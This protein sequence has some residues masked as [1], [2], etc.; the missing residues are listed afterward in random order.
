MV[1]FWN[2]SSNSRSIETI[3]WHFILE[4]AEFWTHFFWG[5]VDRCDR[6]RQWRWYITL[7]MFSFFKGEP[8][9]RHNEKKAFLWFDPRESKRWGNPDY[10]LTLIILGFD[11][12]LWTWLLASSSITWSHRIPQLGF[13]YISFSL[14]NIVEDPSLL[15]QRR[16]F[17]FFCYYSI[18]CTRI[19]PI[20]PTC[21]SSWPRKEDSIFS[22]SSSPGVRTLDP[23]K[24]GNKRCWVPLKSIKFSSFLTQWAFRN[25]SFLALQSLLSLFM[26]FVTAQKDLAFHAEMWQEF[27]SQVCF[28]GF[29]YKYDWSRIS[30]VREGNSMAE[31]RSWT[32]RFTRSSNNQLSMTW[33]ICRKDRFLLSHT[34]ISLG[35]RVCYIR[36]IY[37]TRSREIMSFLLLYQSYYKPN[38][39]RREMNE[40]MARENVHEHF[41]H[42][43]SPSVLQKFVHDDNVHRQKLNERLQTMQFS[44]SFAK[45]SRY[46][47]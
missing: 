28:C 8:R 13:R 10:A 21:G 6:T 12:L 27:V 15:T 9:E 17:S 11:G 24:E 4:H 39:L 26:I 43:K 32:L 35:T 36:A 29:C 3:R 20:K 47:Y 25:I 7:A 30:R 22:V 16:L 2:V 44:K 1:K 42:W 34:N 5:D 31:F 46:E 23:N 45:W 19:L 33:G 37:R 14:L 18:L 40:N 38:L 41:S